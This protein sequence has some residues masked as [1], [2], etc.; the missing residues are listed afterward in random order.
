MF[1]A[2]GLGRLG[3]LFAAHNLDRFCDSPARRR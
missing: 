1:T 3:H 2:E